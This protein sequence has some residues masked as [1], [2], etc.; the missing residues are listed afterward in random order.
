MRCGHLIWGIICYCT[1]ACSFRIL[2]KAGEWRLRRFVF[3]VIASQ[4]GLKIH[5]IFQTSKDSDKTNPSTET[6]NTS[7]ESPNTQ[8]FRAG[9]TSVRLKY[10]NLSLWTLYIFDSVCLFTKYFA[11]WTVIISKAEL[12]KKPGT[13][14]ALENDKYIDEL[15]RMIFL[16]KKVSFRVLRS[17]TYVLYLC[18]FVSFLID[19]RSWF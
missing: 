13:S 6:N 8:L 14:G 7:Y 18:C 19:I 16:W 12:Y 17:D 9:E 3:V 1:T 15:I 11:P 5:R 10:I 4:I 2:K